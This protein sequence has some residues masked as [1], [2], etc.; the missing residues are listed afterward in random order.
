[1]LTVTTDD[2]R[3][4][5]DV[6]APQHLAS[7]GV[8]GRASI[9]VDPRV[10]HDTDKTIRAAIELS[11]IV[12]RHNLFVKV[13]ATVAGLPAISAV[14]AEGISVNVTLIFSVQRYLAVIDAYM[15]GLQAAQRVRPGPVQ[16]P[17]GGIVFRVQ[18]GQ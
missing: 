9:E 11:R 15:A 10:A 2:V 3:E 7:D 5:C 6:L 1:M 14:L 8:D 12:Q 4:P 18:G 13:P 16:D 17:F